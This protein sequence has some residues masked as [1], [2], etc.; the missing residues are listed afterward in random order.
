VILLTIGLQ[1]IA[2]RGSLLH[3]DYRTVCPGRPCGARA[4]YTRSRICLGIC[5]AVTLSVP[6]GA[7]MEV[8]N[9]PVPG[10]RD[11][12][13][14]AR[15][16]PH[17]INLPITDG[18]DVRFT[19]LSV[20]QGLSQTRVAQIAQDD[21]GFLWFGTQNGLNRYDGY[22]FKV[23]KNDPKRPSSLSGVFVYAL[24]NDRSGAIW[25]GTDQ[26]LDRF[27]RATE[28]FTH[29]RLDTDNPI[30]IHISEDR[31]GMLWLAT[32]KGLYRLNPGTGS[33]KRF[34][35]DPSDRFSLSSDDIKSS[36]EDRRG[37]FWVANSEG[38]DAFDRATGR[39]A[40][41]VPLHESVREFSFHEDRFGVFWIIYGSGNGLAVFDRATNTLTRYSF[42]GQDP[43]GTALTGVY[44]ILEDRDGTIWFGTMG[45]GLLKFDRARQSVIRY[46]TYPGDLESLA[47][48][49]V[50]SLFEDREGNIWAGLHA[51]APN[52][53]ARRPP[54]FEKF[55][56]GSASASGLGENL[57]N[58]IYEDRQGNLWMGASG[59]LNRVDRS[60]GQYTFY[61][62]EGPA[63]STEVLTILED[64][65]GTLW[66]GTLGHG[67]NSFDRQTGRFNTYLH[68]PIDP[69]SVSHNIVTRLFMD[70]AGSIWATSWN[71]LNR[72]DPATRRFTVFKRDPQS[73]TESYFSIDEDSQGYLWLGST[74][75]LV[76]F[77]PST[78]QF[79][80]FK[81]NPD[82][83]KTLS[84]NTVN[85]VYVDRFDTVWLG[86]QNGLNRLEPKTGSFTVFYEKD[87][88]PGN[89]VS[90]VLEDGRGALWISTNNGLSRFD[91]LKRTFTNYSAADGLPGGDLTA[92][93]TCFRSPS[94][95]MFFGGFA[96]ATA[97]HPE[98]VL[99][100]TYIPPVVLTD[101]RL[102]GAT[103]E[104]GPGS[105]LKRSIT[106]AEDL[107]LFHEQDAF[108]VQFSA[109]SF[110]SPQTNRYRYKL[111]GL[112]SS[113]H[114]VGSEQRLASYTTLPA[115]VYQFRVQGATSRGPWSE[116]DTALRIE[117]LPPW[118]NTWWFRTVIAALFVLSLLAVYY[119]RLRQ[120]AQ[121]LEMRL[122]ERVGERT[123]I[124]RE[125]HDSLLQGFQGLMFRLQAVRDLL[126]ARPSEAVQVLDAALDRGDQAIVEGREAVQDLR[127]NTVVSNDLVQAVAALGEELSQSD[128][129]QG[130]ASFRVLEEGKPRTLD[131][132]VRDEIYR[133]AREALRNAF[134]H[135]Y[136]RKIEAEISY[137]ESQFSLRIR[138]DGMGIDA[139][140]LDRG[141]LT[142]HWGLPGMRER[143]KGF[144]GALNVWSKSGAG[145]EIELTIPAVA[146]YSRSSAGARFWFSRNRRESTR[147]H[148][149]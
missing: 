84:N 16:D 136:A 89:A 46:R 38:L 120:M 110:F 109:L 21:Q 61:R 81:H 77:E 49:R 97:F 114:E 76:R 30:V 8:S 141:S 91:P 101:F 43:T 104:P 33:I 121:Q 75:G 53:F 100:N 44:A 41:H 88:L 54:P 92:W 113:W 147:A 116:P 70:R 102:S 83:P 48:N 14:R 29:H 122:E 57:V 90:C 93:G 66:V 95:E 78:G 60:T 134:R 107:T 67:L 82:D 23:F 94:G 24:F 25:V 86:T 59:A 42:Y 138:D 69:A 103:V 148:D 58:A 52:F 132:I 125:L 127:S 72:F 11:A 79:T 144:G 56:P 35:H 13:Q 65:S 36:G 74:S 80:L 140:V 117:I 71:G 27:D 130:S 137:G 28:T 142:G 47:E 119:Y 50:I 106:Y 96:G 135:A 40:I 5:F 17:T 19:R 20:A 105:P 31:A 3:A 99:D 2:Q 68:D 129:S 51:M 15:V 123:R 112:D 34:G 64:R 98:K 111:E 85:S 45:A 145:T 115:G 63:V 6:C 87:G 4:L 128:G 32:S 131:P 149:D 146:A 108:S 22:S 124:A 39:V 1:E 18:K 133:I 118:W 139:L 73:T 7:A 37:T 62:P 126:P 12:V 26:Y 143:A 55:Q 9:A 10:P